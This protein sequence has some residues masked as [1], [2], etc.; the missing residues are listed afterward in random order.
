MKRPFLTAI[1]AILSLAV[2]LTA[3]E[4]KPLIGI[5]PSFSNNTLQLNNDYVTAVQRNGGIAIILAPTDDEKTIDAYVRMLDG[6]VFSGGP[7][8]PPEFYGQTQH[9]TTSIMEP[10]R[11]EFERRFIKAFLDSNKPVLGICLGMQFSNVCRGG[12]LIQDIPELVGKKVSHRDGSMYTNFHHVAMAPGSLLEKILQTRRTRVISRH[13]QAID[14]LGTGFIPS[15][16]SSDGIIEAMER[17]DGAF[18]IFV[19]WHPESMKDA[20][21]D[22]TDR[23]FK[24]LITAARAQKD[25]PAEW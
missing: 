18:G 9:A 5:T 7:D 17:N 16:R 24:A 10:A 11:F 21:P 13:H 23:L 20:D 4:K 19:Q 22:H 6:A 8:I 14:K 12:T 1:L 25:Q 2:S 15:A 3:A